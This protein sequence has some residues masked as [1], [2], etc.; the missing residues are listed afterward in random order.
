MQA[1]HNAMGGPSPIASSPTSPIRSRGSHS[2]DPYEVKRN[3]RQIASVDASNGQDMPLGCFFTVA[4]LREELQKVVI[5]PFTV[6]LSEMEKRF[7]EIL[8][9]EL[10]VGSPGY[11]SNVSS[12]TLAGGIL[13]K[14]EGAIE[15]GNGS[16][17]NCFEYVEVGPQRPQDLKLF[18]NW[19][20]PEQLDWSRRHRRG[21]TV[22]Q[23]MGQKGAENRGMDIR[24]HTSAGFE[25]A[26]QRENTGE[27][28]RAL[29]ATMNIAETLERDRTRTSSVLD[30]YIAQ[31][32]PEEVVNEAPAHSPGLLRRFMLYILE[33][34]EKEM[35]GAV[36]II[37]NA[38]VMGIQTEYIARHA[39]EEEEPII[40]EWIE[41]VFLTIFTVDLIMHLI[42][43]GS[44]L[45]S[46]DDVL[47]HVFDC[48]IVAMQLGDEVAKAMDNKALSK[49]M[50]S[51]SVLRL[52]HI[53]RLVRVIRLARILRLIGELRAIILSIFATVQSLAWI[54]VILMLFT[55][56]VGVYITQLVTVHVLSHEELADVDPVFKNNFGTLG[57]TILS[58]YQAVCGG[59]L[60]KDLLNPLMEHISPWTSLIFCL[61]SGFVLF[62]LMNIATGVFV[63]NV[64]RNS[65]NDKE[66]YLV[67][68]V[69]EVF[70]AVDEDGSGQI[71]W[72]E[73]SSQLDTPEMRQ[74]FKLLDVDFTM[75]EAEQLFRLLD[76]DGS[77]EIDEEEFVSGCLHLHGAAKAMDM[78]VLTHE[79]KR[80]F[81]ISMM[82]FESIHEALKWIVAILD[83]PNKKESSWTGTM[84][85][86]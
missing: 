70:A 84:T 31:I 59:I 11:P 32:A 72:E 35:F 12:I 7:K 86:A 15:N 26:E 10:R 22:G 62:A 38:L 3:R 79:F 40:F 2:K 74:Y 66:H 21:Y 1:A 85:S 4:Q 67:E 18:Q 80:M 6:K 57:R 14:S 83:M 39:T 51:V 23:E 49:L 76:T 27:S 24:T 19:D 68:V 17:T 16:S 43:F 77:G 8:Q 71:S 42:A 41:R 81:H 29:V 75:E 46:T 47:W 28:S 37:L 53:L 63:E 64:R 61:Y 69:R 13:D 50:S 33:S 44:E 73:F 78:E 34:H 82:H 36:V 56:M 5:E 45:F 20:L 60:W 48:F 65:D 52:F 30:R 9:D 25:L 54:L 55:F 58:L